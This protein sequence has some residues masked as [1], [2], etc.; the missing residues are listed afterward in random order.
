MRKHWF[1]IGWIRFSKPVVASFSLEARQ[2]TYIACE[3]QPGRYEP[4]IP[5]KPTDL[6]TGLRLWYVPLTCYISLEA[7]YASKVKKKET[8]R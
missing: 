7:P 3:W 5:N 4:S 6:Y 1:Q 2:G 8:K